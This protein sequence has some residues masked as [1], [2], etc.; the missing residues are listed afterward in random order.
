M[1]QRAVRVG[2]IHVSF[3][4]TPRVFSCLLLHVLLSYLYTDWPQCLLY[5]SSRANTTAIQTPTVKEGVSN[6]RETVNPDRLRVWPQ[7]SSLSLLPTHISPDF[8][9]LVMQFC[10]AGAEKPSETHWS[11]LLSEVGDGVRWWSSSVFAK[12]AVAVTGQAHA[13]ASI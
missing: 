13:T 11:H 8:V 4:H 5:N 1:A 7:R 6:V 3:F 2:S 9:L 10:F 12:W